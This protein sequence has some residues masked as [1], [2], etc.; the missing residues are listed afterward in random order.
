M[1]S[2]DRL[3]FEALESVLTLFPGKRWVIAYSGGLDS[4]VLLYAAVHVS[5]SLR[6]IHI[7]HGLSPDAKVWAEHCLHQ[8]RAYGVMCE[9]LNTEPFTKQNGQS[10]ETW[11]RAQRYQIFEQ[12]LQP[13]EILLFAHHQQDQAETLLL[14]LM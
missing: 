4:T 13:D 5:D 12:H 2:S 9:S 14:N 10:V 7:N 11:A 6:A 3:I 8:A 1:P